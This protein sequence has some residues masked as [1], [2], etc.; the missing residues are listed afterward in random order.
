MYVVC[1]LEDLSRLRIQLPLVILIFNLTPVT[2]FCSSAVENERLFILC[3][4]ALLALIPS[5]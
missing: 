3:P 5:L 1:G 2:H 4:E